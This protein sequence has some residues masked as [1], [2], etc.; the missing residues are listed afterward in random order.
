[1]L[2]RRL[3]TL[4]KPLDPP[5]TWPHCALDVFLCRRGFDDVDMMMGITRFLL[6]QDGADPSAEGNKLLSYALKHPTRKVRETPPPYALARLR[7]LVLSRSVFV[8]ALRSPPKQLEALVAHPLG[9]EVALAAVPPRIFSSFTELTSTSDKPVAPLLALTAPRQS[10]PLLVPLS[11]P[12]DPLQ[13]EG[14]A[15]PDGLVQ[16][17]ESTAFPYLAE[18]GRTLNDCIHQQLILFAVVPFL[19]GFPFD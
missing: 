2:L 16:L 15:Y 13:L 11:A 10:S 19:T 5:R 4:F 14:L 9:T 8:G 7:L 6:A 18:V 3:A 1:M 17:V 12:R